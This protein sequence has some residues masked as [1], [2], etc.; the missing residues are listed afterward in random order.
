ML[1]LQL[2]QWAIKVLRNQHHSQLNKQQKHVQKLR[3]DFGVYMQMNTNTILAKK[4][5]FTNRWVRQM[6]QNGYID[7]VATDAHNITYRA[8]KMK[9]CHR[10]LADQYG[11]AYA[12]ELCGGFQRKVLEL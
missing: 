10:A 3:D 4:G 7:C 5:F 11:E 8:C 12:D 6:L 2:V 9:A 1:G